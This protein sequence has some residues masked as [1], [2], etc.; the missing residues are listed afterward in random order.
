MAETQFME[1][2][3]K[4]CLILSRHDGIEDKLHHSYQGGGKSTALKLVVSHGNEKYLKEAKKFLVKELGVTLEEEPHHGKGGWSNTILILLHNLSEDSLNK[5]NV[6]SKAIIKK[7]NSL[8]KK[9]L[10]VKKEEPMVIDNTLS[11]TEPVVKKQGMSEMAKYRVALSRFLR[12]IMDSEGISPKDFPFTKESGVIVT[13]NCKTELIAKMIEMSISYS[14]K[15]IAIREGNSVM[16]DCSKFAGREN[17]KQFA[18]PP[19]PGQSINVLREK[20]A[21]VYPYKFKNIELLDNGVSV[22]FKTRTLIPKIIKIFGG[23]GWDVSNLNENSIFIKYYDENMMMGD[24]NIVDNLP[25]KDIKDERVN[26]SFN[27]D[28]LIK[29]DIVEKK[30]SFGHLTND[31]IICELKSISEKFSNSLSPETM[32]RIE[33]AL[34][35]DLKEKDPEKYVRLLLE[36]LGY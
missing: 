6:L 14:S 13:V 12:P 8:K 18:F 1:L 10:S 20:M 35:D 27:S 32:E 31:Q 7:E 25:K 24:V 28:L 16:V 11:S 4:I 5:I 3:K 2:G 30:R 33:K 23:M 36:K 34:M 22:Y 21:R 29:E 26:N 9:D 15:D 17:H 19:K